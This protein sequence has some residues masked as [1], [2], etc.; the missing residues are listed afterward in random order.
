MVAASPKAPEADVHELLLLAVQSRKFNDDRRAQL[1]R[2][3]TPRRLPRRQ[4]NAGVTRACLDWTKGHLRPATHQIQEQSRRAQSGLLSASGCRTRFDLQRTKQTRS[5]PAGL[6]STRQELS[7][8]SRF[9][10]S[11]ITQ[12]EPTRKQPLTNAR[13]W[14]GLSVH[15]HARKQTP[16]R[17]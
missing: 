14:P 4:A 13:S 12:A 5:I 15:R 17:K 1:D 9:A 6:P 8:R 10:T 3:S 2:C 11:S 7:R 16:A